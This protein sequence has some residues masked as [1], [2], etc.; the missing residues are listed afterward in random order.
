M[1][2]VTPFLMFQGQAEEAMNYYISVI[3]D[4]EIVNIT[5]YGA[6]GPGGE[7]SVMLAVLSIK[8]QEFMCMD[9]NV[10]HEF[11]F[12]PSFSIYIT[13]DAEEEI[14]RYYELLLKG[15]QALMAIGDY[16]FSKKFGWIVDQFG[17]SWQFNLPH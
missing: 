7:G 13:C 11:T 15:G 8:G 16:G 1:S 5:R 12:T 6:D 10:K 9:S 17:V 2:R 4:S 14:D 3:E